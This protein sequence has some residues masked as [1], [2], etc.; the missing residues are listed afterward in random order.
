M[1]AHEGE[2]V[3]GVGATGVIGAL[4]FFFFFLKTACETGSIKSNLTMQGRTPDK[5]QKETG[6]KSRELQAP[7]TFFFH[8]RGCP[9]VSAVAGALDAH[10]KY[11][12]HPSFL[13]T[14]IHPLSLS[15]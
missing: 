13:P 11:L 6:K 10:L 9:R 12:S 1:L 3:T 14:G 5:S 15:P 7:Y 8:L 4:F 2:G